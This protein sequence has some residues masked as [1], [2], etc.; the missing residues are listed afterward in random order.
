MESPYKMCEKGV[1]RCSALFVCGEKGQIMAINAM[2]NVKPN[3]VGS[4][5]FDGDTTTSDLAEYA[6]SMNL[7]LGTTAINAD[8]GKVYIMNSEYQFKQL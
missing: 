2:D 1:T 4:L 3:G 8:D 7:Q 6:E 5:A